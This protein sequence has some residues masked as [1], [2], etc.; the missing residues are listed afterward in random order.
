MNPK[1]HT[2]SHGFTLLELAI[3][4]TI[5]GVIIGTGLMTLTAAVQA[6]EYNATVAKM[7]AIDKALL[8]F[9]TKWNRIPCPGDLTLTPTSLASGT[10]PA[11][12]IASSYY[13]NTTVMAGADYGA[14]AGSD[15][16]SA[17]GVGT[18]VC[19]GTNMTPQANFSATSGVAEGA[20]P[21]KA[22]DLSDDY[23]YDG[24][25]RR[26]RYAVDP[27]A[28]VAGSIPS[29]TLSCSPITIY[30]SLGNVRSA[31]AIYAII[32]HG[33]NGHGAYTSSGTTHSA[34]STN[35]NKQINCHCNNSGTSIGY[36]LPNYEPSG[37]ATNLTSA[38]YVQAVPS[39]ATAGTATTTFDDIVSY[40]ES[41]QMQTFN[42]P[43]TPSFLYTADI[44]NNRVRKIS[45]TMA[46]IITTIAGNGTQGLT[47]DGGAATSAELDDPQGVAVD[48]SGNIYI[49]NYFGQCI[50]KVTAATGII[51]TIAGNTTAGACNGT[52]GHTGDG[53]QATSA[54]LS[55]PE[56]VAVDSSGNIYIADYF[57][58]CIRKVTAAT[59][60]MSTVAGHT[61]AGACDDTSGHTGDTG[62]ATSAKLNSPSGV[63]L[64]SFG[65]IY[66]TDSGNNCIRK[67]MAS[68]NII[69]TV[70]GNTTAGACNASAG[71]Y[72]GDGGQ[73]TSATLNGPGSVAVDSSGD[74]YIADGGNNRIR[75]VTAATGIIST[76][77]G[78]GG[79][80]CCGTGGYSG[81]YGPATSARLN[82]PGDIALDSYGNLY[83]A[84]MSNQVIRKVTASGTICTVAGN[85]YG[86]GGTGAY[87]GDNGPATKAELYFPGSVAISTVR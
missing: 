42:N 46:G 62:A 14:E 82:T 67:V 11:S 70:A 25:G 52:S 33:A 58:N 18:G 68:T 21:T 38:T 35:Q 45:A 8:T 7:A 31:A 60:I 6:T 57:N 50:R 84:D 44:S 10:S 69:T 65:N 73:A 83:I 71:A 74:I 36:P 16:S 41:G 12:S 20:V 15:A 56:K 17:I 64:D 55:F 51:T 78:S 2:R 4:L 34:S 32:S 5:I 37:T 30:D 23:L 9:S 76:V 75:K 1:I 87:S 59:G 19:V 63:T 79:F 77:A 27:S 39:V 54:K 61:T 53:G 48:S 49:G 86:A 72:S 43:V 13:A 80:G 22:L 28:T 24:W 29:M 47:G 26:F 66:I 85:G 40:K 81:D 3:V